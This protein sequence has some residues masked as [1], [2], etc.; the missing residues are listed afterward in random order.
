MQPARIAHSVER[1]RIL[2]ECVREVAA[3]LRLIELSDLV[4]HLKTMQLANV[5]MLVQSSVELWFKR[6]TLRFAHSGNA[7][8]SWD[9][10]PQ[11]SLDMEFHH[12]SV[13]VYFQLV[14]EA[15]RAGIDISFISFDRPSADPEINTRRMHDAF[16]DARA[17]KHED[18]GESVI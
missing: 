5:D 12:M 11:I 10:Q 7:H 17:N 15:R 8:L 4:A 2:A 13:H 18:A 16:L 3:D 1:E 9:T 14:L 6:D